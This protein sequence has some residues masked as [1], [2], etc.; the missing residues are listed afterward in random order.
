[1]RCCTRDMGLRSR[2]RHGALRTERRRRLLHKVSIGIFPVYSGGP[3]GVRA[4]CCASARPGGCAGQVRRGRGRDPGKHVRARAQN[5]RRMTPGAN[6]TS[7]RFPIPPQSI[8]STFGNQKSFGQ[9]CARETAGRQ[10]IRSSI[11]LLSL[12]LESHIAGRKLC[13]FFSRH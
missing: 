9:S 7:N 12:N 11:H 8:G 10:T 1:M 4:A 2:L 6:A 13:N 5:S 3:A